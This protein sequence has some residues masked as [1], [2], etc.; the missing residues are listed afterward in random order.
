MVYQVVEKEEPNP[1]D[2]EKQ[3]KAL[4]EDV[5]Q[6]KRGLAFEAFRT[7]LEERLKKDGTVK[8]YQDKMKTFGGLGLG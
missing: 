1:A 2:F 6:S 4:S 5:V 3:K 7:A 8:I